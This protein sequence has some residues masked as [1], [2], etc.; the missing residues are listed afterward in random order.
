MKITEQILLD[1]TLRHME[2][3]EVTG[4]RQY[5]FTKGKSCLYKFGDLLRQGYSVGG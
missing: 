1:I 3:Q 4:F 5:G 2:N